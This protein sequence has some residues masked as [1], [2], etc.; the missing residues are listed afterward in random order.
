MK[1]T[2]IL[3]VPKYAFFNRVEAGRNSKLQFILSSFGRKLVL[4][5]VGDFL[6]KVHK[7]SEAATEIFSSIFIS[8]FPLWMRYTLV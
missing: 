3:V 7:I 6:D 8:N 4:F 5:K 2:E 1:K